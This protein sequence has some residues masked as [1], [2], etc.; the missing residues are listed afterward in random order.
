MKRKPSSTELTTPLASSKE[1]MKRLKSPQNKRVLAKKAP[2]ISSI[3]TRF[4]AVE[5]K[6]RLTVTTLQRLQNP[7]LVNSKK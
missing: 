1:V 3:N 2:E 4:L 6:T 7:K 5:R